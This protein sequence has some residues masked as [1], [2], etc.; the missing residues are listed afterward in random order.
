[1]ST[2][3]N[4][5]F[6]TIKAELPNL[7]WKLGSVIR[8]LVVDPLVHISDTLDKLTTD[9]SRYNEL[10]VALNDPSNHEDVLDMWLAKLNLNVLNEYAAP[11][12]GIVRIV[13]N[14]AD[15]MTIEAGTS[16]QW[17]S[18]VTLL[19]DST[20]IW[21]I[22]GPGNKYD[23][24]AA[25][26]VYIADIPVTSGTNSSLTLASGS[27]IN[28]PTADDGVVEVYLATSITGGGLLSA[29]KKASIIRAFLAN[30][31]VCG[32]NGVKASLLR[33]FPQELVDAQ[34]GYRQ[35]TDCAASVPVYIKQTNYPDIGTSGQITASDTA[36]A[37]A[38]LNSKQVGSPFKFYGKSPVYGFLSLAINLG[39][40]FASEAMLAEICSYINQSPLN[41]TLTDTGIS[42]ILRKYSVELQ[43]PITYVA[44]VFNGTANY[45]VTQ[46]GSLSLIGVTGT[47]EAPYALYCDMN[48]ITVY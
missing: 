8:T 3:F 18:S 19:A 26:S 47:S 25:G 38:W 31:T 1:M 7:N 22:N 48:S 2:I 32:S 5:L 4:T 11:A 15:P 44:D 37:V 12:S 21:S 16:F 33:K 10:D 36:D 46:T 17:G 14:N 39:E 23:T 20:T 27:P 24:A 45:S 30:P 42:D 43:S 40:S 35:V 29:D 34:V 28:W 9:Q 13:R 6:N 41:A